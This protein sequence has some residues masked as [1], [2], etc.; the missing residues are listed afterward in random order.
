MVDHKVQNT[1]VASI[2]KDQGLLTTVVARIVHRQVWVCIPVVGQDYLSVA[3][4][5]NIDD[6]LIGLI[7]LPNV[8][9]VSRGTINPAGVLDQDQWDEDDNSWESDTTI[10][11]Q[12][13]FSPTNDSLMFTQPGAGKLL[14][15]DIG[16]SADGSDITASM[17]HLSLRVGDGIYHSTVTQIV[18]LFEGQSGDVV[19]VRIGSQQNFDH[20]I[21]WLPAQD[22][23]IGQSESVSQIIDGRYLSVRYEITSP[24]YWRMYGY[25][26]KIKQSGEY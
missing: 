6:P 3:Y 25:H 16:A 5:I 18:P 22:F 20:P 12:S 4:V 2:D 8:A 21:N 13:T 19:S 11:T 10:W 14:A 26:L 24:N 15:N 7:T 9:S 1:L 17:E 23:I